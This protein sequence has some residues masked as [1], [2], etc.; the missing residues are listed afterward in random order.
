[1]NQKLKQIDMLDFFFEN[2][3]ESVLYI[4]CPQSDVINVLIMINEYSFQNIFVY[5][6]YL[7]PIVYF[8]FN[9]YPKCSY[10]I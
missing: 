2:K 9:I 6:Y 1:M 10:S 3:L 8:F 7:Y 5:D 4:S